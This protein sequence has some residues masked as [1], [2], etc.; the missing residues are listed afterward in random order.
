MSIHNKCTVRHCVKYP[1]KLMCAFQG[2][3]SRIPKRWLSLWF[4]VS[5][6]RIFFPFCAITE[7]KVIQKHRCNVSCFRVAFMPNSKSVSA[8]GPFNQIRSYFRPHTSLMSEPLMTSQNSLFLHGHTIGNTLLSA[9]PAQSADIYRWA[10]GWKY[11]KFIAGTHVTPPLW[12]NFKNPLHLCTRV[13]EYEDGCF[14]EMVS[15]S[16]V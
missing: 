2:D 3:S 8:I 1:N 10:W 13:F 14:Q 16:V 9:E 5:F 7:L 11:L 4:K 12:A 6:C 15:G